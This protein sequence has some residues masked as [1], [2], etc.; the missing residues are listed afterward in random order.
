MLD[1]EAL[2]RKYGPMVLRR[3]RSLLGDEER[4]RDAM[5]ET[6][7]KVLRR[8]DSLTEAAPSSL[9]YCIATNICLNMI[10]A[11]K[12]RPEVP[13]GELLEQLAG[14]DS[15]ETLGQ[16]RHLIEAI[17]DREETSTRTMAVLVYVDG[18]TLEEAATRVGLSVSGL[19]R[20]LAGLRGRAKLF[21]EVG[22]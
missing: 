8:R 12:R 15:P 17:F 5:Q 14:S 7:V 2:Y 16:A 9:L 21:L 18:L 20:R 10:R 4:A 19:R 22:E 6:F 13:G 11:S 1:V 3:C